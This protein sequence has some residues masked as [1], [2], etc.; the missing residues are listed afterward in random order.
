MTPD[1]TAVESSRSS[2]STKIFLIVAIFSLPIGVLAYLLAANYTPQIASAQLELTGNTLQKPLMKALYGLASS[3]NALQGCEAAT[4][5]AN[6]STQTAVVSSSLDAAS[7]VNN[8]VAADLNT[9]TDALAKKNHKDLAFDNLQSEWKVLAA[10]S[11]KVATPADREEL[12]NGYDHLSAQIKQLVSYAG[13][14]SGLILDP[15]LDSY[16]LVDVTLLAMPET[17]AQISNTAAIGN[18]LI[19]G[20]PNAAVDQAALTNESALLEGSINRMAASNS[21]TFDADA[22]NHG[23]SPTLQPKLTPALQSYKAA[24]ASYVNTLRSIGA[25]PSQ[26]SAAALASQAAALQKA[27]LDYWETGASELDGL[28]NL[29]IADFETSRIQ[30]LGFSALAVVLATII[31]FLIGRSITKPLRELVRNL[32][33][34]ATLLGVSVERI[35]EAGQSKTPSAEESAII[36]EELNAHAENMRKAVLELARHVEGSAAA[37]RLAREDAGQP[38]S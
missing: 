27:S 10:A 37:S 18:R 30:A 32:A 9:S 2:V 16:Y 34:G 5:I 21:T 25:N 15:D 19:A 12:A 35:A 14:T 28:L 6:L 7:A 31:A 13:D 33:P 38:R 3:K 36:C 11:A 29:R 1:S 22:A 20:S 8:Q 4:C 17:V 23:V 24:A 26:T